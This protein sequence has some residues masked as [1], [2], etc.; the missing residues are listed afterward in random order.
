[1]D[2]IFALANPALAPNLPNVS[3]TV[4]DQFSWLGVQDIVQIAQY[5]E[6]EFKVWFYC[7]NDFW[8]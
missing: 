3:S 1:M 5:F 6:L 4:T 7:E 8:R 2:V